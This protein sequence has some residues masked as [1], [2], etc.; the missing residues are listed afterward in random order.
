MNFKEEITVNMG[1][2]LEFMQKNKEIFPNVK[3]DFV[4]WAYQAV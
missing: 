4:L 1:K 2:L 3:L